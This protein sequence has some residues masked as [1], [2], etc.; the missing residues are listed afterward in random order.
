[1]AA[2]AGTS[3]YWGLFAVSTL[4]MIAMLIWMNEWFWLALPFSLTFL[5]KALNVIDAD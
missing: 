2:T 1:M 5:V 3:K 4:V